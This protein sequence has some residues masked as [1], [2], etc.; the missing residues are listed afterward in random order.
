MYFKEIGCESDRI[1]YLS[2]K[3]IAT[4]TKITT[5]RLQKIEMMQV[6]NLECEIV[7]NSG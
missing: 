7:T 2:T 1:I 6:T 4:A 3:K 5:G